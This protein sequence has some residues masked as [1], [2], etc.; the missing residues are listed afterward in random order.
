L[1]EGQNAKEK[2]EVRKKI[3]K[4][5][6]SEPTRRLRVTEEGLRVTLRDTLKCYSR[7]VTPGHR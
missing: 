5:Q 2:N 6:N 4:W 7:R 1:I 3:T